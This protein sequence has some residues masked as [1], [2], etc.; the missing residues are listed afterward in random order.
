MRPGGTSGAAT[1]S[2]KRSYAVAASALRAR[3]AAAS[4]FAR[5]DVSMMRLRTSEVS[6]FVFLI[7]SAELKLGPATAGRTEVRPTSAIVRPGRARP[8][9]ACCLASPPRPG[10]A[11][12]PRARLR[13]L[14][15]GWRG[16]F[17]QRLASFDSLIGHAEQ[18]EVAGGRMHR[19]APASHAPAAGIGEHLV[20]GSHRPARDT[21]ADEQR[22]PLRTR[23]L[24]QHRRRAATRARRSARR[25]PRWW[26]TAIAD[27]R[28]AVQSLATTAATARRSRRR[29]PA[30][31][32]PCRT[33]RT[34]RSTDAGCPCGPA[35]ARREHDPGLI[36]EQRRDRVE[37]RDVDVLPLAGRLPREQRQQD[38]LGGEHP[39]DDVHDGDAEPVAAGRR[40]HR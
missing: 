29:A 31:R 35:T 25:E 34:A 1:V 40:R 7:R 18:R 21:G 17:E 19:R 2:R 24:R 3:R 15:Q 26:R 39:R 6:M 14:A 37:H 9:S 12:T 8:C 13:V 5:V 10:S 20:N 33:C 4:P 16:A 36:R 32:R 23:A 22:R 28:L 27:E 11:P 30:G 38:P